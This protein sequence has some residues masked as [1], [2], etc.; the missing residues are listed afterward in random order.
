MSDMIGKRVS[1]RIGADLCRRLAEEVALN[2]RSESEVVREALEMYL[3]TR[4]RRESCYE[5]FR[6]LG[7]I[8]MLKNAPPDLSANRRY[9]KGFGRK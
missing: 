4:P 9:F 7:L 5:A 3:A 1:I 8:G 2:S 6:R